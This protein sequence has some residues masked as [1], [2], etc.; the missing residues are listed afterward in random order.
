MDIDK[1]LTENFLTAIEAVFES[2]SFDAVTQMAF[3]E[4]LDQE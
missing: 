1:S 2:D 4:V 3:E